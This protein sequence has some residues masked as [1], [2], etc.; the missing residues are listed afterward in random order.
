MW[1]PDWLYKVLPL[2]Y[3]VSGVFAIYHAGNLVGQGSGVL[4]ILTA[5]LVWK[6]RKDGGTNRKSRS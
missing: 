6:L 1:L 4:L 3:T 5:L 2:L